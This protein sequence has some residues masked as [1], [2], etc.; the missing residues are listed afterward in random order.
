MK[1]IVFA[2]LALL[3][4]L[5]LGCQTPNAGP[6]V[7]PGPYT[8]PSVQVDSFAPR[9]Q[10]VVTTPTGG[11]DVGV[12]QVRQSG[13]R[14]QVFITAVRPARDQM[15][16]QALQRHE[17]NSTIDSRIPIDIFIRVVDRGTDPAN[18]PYRTAGRTEPQ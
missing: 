9:H 8:G 12:D 17:L 15:V 4:T 11:W 3:V 16:T 10:V 13:Q 7:D 14:R 2:P 1:P 18:F 6:R 5:I